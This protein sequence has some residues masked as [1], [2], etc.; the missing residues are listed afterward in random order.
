MTNLFVL[1]VYI[2][3]PCLLHPLYPTPCT[4]HPTPP[5]HPLASPACT[6]CLHAISLQYR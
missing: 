1:E 2:Y 5:L 6:I 3:S 4:V